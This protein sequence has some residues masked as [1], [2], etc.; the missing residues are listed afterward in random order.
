MNHTICPPLNTF[1]LITQLRRPANAHKGL[2]GKVLLIGGAHGMMGAL[3][4]AGRASLLS[5]AGWTVSMMLDAAG[6]AASAL[7]PELMIQTDE[8]IANKAAYLQ[9]IKPS[10]I[11]IG[12]GLGNSP[13]AKEWLETVLHSHISHQSPRL[14]IDAD[15]LNVLAQQVGLF[16]QLQR[17]TKQHPNSVVITPHASEAGRLLKTSIQLVENNRPQAL[18]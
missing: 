17:C 10:T 12:T 3:L 8:R 4:L 18:A 7:Q 13:Q 2:A 15:A 1:D 14:V 9:A 6:A 5:G 16:E 11:G